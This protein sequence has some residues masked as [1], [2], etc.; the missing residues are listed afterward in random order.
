MRGGTREGPQQQRAL[1]K[2]RR[3]GQQ[4]A[5]VLATPAVAASGSSQLPAA[6]PLQQRP[7]TAA[8]G[9]SSGQRQGQQ[10]RG[11]QASQPAAPRPA[12]AA[13]P[14]ADPAEDPA[15]GPAAA[16]PSEQPTPSAAVS[17]SRIPPATPFSTPQH[18][19]AAAA[20][21]A[22]AA[23]AAAQAVT[24][25]LLVSEWPVPV[26][27]I[28]RCSSCVCCTGAACP[29]WFCAIAARAQRCGAGPLQR[30]L[31]IPYCAAVCCAVLPVPVLV[32]RPRH[33]Y[34]AELQ[35]CGECVNRR[36]AARCCRHC[37]TQSG[38]EKGTS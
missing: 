33:H 13:H 37:C 2:G 24:H 18:S 5:A 12:A 7:A 4:A 1:Q 34:S 29:C 11:Q 25:N 28:C 17:T 38:I 9:S 3:P 31:C 21:A 16:G 27:F 8:S 22:V 36:S 23:A 6:M 35:A 26:Y 10:H 19:A 14:A 32:V 30:S 15:A 20:A